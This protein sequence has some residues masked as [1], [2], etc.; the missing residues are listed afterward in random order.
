MR[1][2]NAIAI[3]VFGVLSFACSGV[4]VAISF[5]WNDDYERWQ[6]APVIQEGQEVGELQAIGE[7][8]DVVVVGTIDPAMPPSD[9]GL[10]IYSYW[11]RKTTGSGDHRRQSW[12]LVSA[13][14]HTPAFHLLLGGQAIMIEPKEFVDLRNTR[15]S[16]VSGGAKL[17]GFA[18]GDGVTVFGAVISAGVPFEVEASTICGGERQECLEIFARDILVFFIVAAILILIGGGLVWVGVRQ[19]SKSG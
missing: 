12:E 19:Y 2:L 7:G 18:P 10:A 11:R 9:E 14:G 16:L 13:R 8:S 3:I 1:R 4:L 17:I 15:E 5:T 6:A